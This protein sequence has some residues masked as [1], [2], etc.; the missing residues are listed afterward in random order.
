MRAPR[1]IPPLSPAQVSP[2]IR[3]TPPLAKYVHD[4]DGHDDGHDDADAKDLSDGADANDANDDACANDADDNDNDNDN[5]NNNDGGGG[6]AVRHQ[7]QFPSTAV[8]S[9][10]KE[11]FAQPRCLTFSRLGSHLLCYLPVSV[12]KTI[13]A[14]HRPDSSSSRIVH[15]FSAHVL[16]TASNRDPSGL[17]HRSS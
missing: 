5:D 1:Q 16:G 17:S 11:T 3:T 7:Y 15:A 8:G 4:D 12:T 14:V 10:D 2:S 6:R 13:W 9:E